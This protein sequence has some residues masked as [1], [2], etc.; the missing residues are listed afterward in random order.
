MWK[1]YPKTVKKEYMK[2]VGGFAITCGI[3]WIVRA[4]GTPVFSF[5]C[6][7]VELNVVSLLYLFMEMLWGG[8]LPMHVKNAYLIDLV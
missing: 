5:Y 8:S 2:S 7:K 1:I 4:W 3:L 6:A